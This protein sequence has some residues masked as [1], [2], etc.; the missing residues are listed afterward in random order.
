MKEPLQ[1][2][3]SL[4]KQIEVLRQNTGFYRPEPVDRPDHKSAVEIFQS[5]GDAMVSWRGKRYDIQSMLPAIDK[6]VG[7]LFQDSG[8]TLDPSKG[9]LLKGNPGTGKTMLMKIFSEV[10]RCFKMGFWSSGEWCKLTPTTYY[11]RS[12]V[13][14][15][16]ASE[17]P[18]RYIG[19]IS[20]HPCICIED[21]GA[22]ADETMIYGNRLNVIARL[23]DVRCEK[24]R[25][26]FGTTNLEKFSDK[27][28]DRTISRL[29]GLFNVIVLDHG[30]DFRRK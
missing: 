27:Y 23:V 26:T 22:E 14:D 7:W 8:S 18:Y 24:N 2:R 10:V 21:I 15:Y 19:M 5:L 29:N 9:I 4:A 13:N 25:L 16:L 20:K 28:D 17:E 1:I 12:I 30:R 11:S 6:M 3:E